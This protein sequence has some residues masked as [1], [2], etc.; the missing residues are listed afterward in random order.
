MY[1]AMIVPS[2][3]LGRPSG[4]YI[5]NRNGVRMCIPYYGSNN[6]KILAYC[7][8]Y[9]IPTLVLMQ[10]YGSIFHSKRMQAMRRATKSATT[11]T[12]SNKY[13]SMNGNAIG[14]EGKCIP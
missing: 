10:C 12:T 1:A 8:Y 3:S 14:Q 2:K 9:F 7:M 4:N 6:V 13:A 11:T 5:F